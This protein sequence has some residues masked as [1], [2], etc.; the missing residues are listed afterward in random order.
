MSSSA[1][2]SARPLSKNQG[3][4]FPLAEGETAVAAA[5][6][7]YTRSTRRWQATHGRSRQV[8]PTYKRPPQAPRRADDE[9]VCDVG[10]GH[11]AE[12]DRW[13]AELIERSPTAIALAKQS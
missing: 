8:I 2:P 6:P 10:Q 1:R 5:L 7:A 12:V 3:G 4:T 13:C 9:N 11:R